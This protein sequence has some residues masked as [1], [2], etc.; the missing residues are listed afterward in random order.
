MMVGGG[1]GMEINHMTT[2]LTNTHARTDTFF[3]LSENESNF[4][5]FPGNIFIFLFF[6]I[7]MI[8]NFFKICPPNP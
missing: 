4:S 7:V 2:N 5:I 3:F 8:Y 1:Y 6:F